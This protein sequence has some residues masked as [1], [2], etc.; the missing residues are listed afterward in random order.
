M[1]DKV[2]IHLSWAAFEEQKGNGVKSAEILEKLES[3]HPNLVNVMLSRINLERR[4]GNVDS[5]HKLFKSCI[6]KASK[7]KS[8]LAMKY[9]RYLR[10]GLGDDNA[11]LEVLQKALERDTK[12]AKLYLQML[13]IALHARPLDV[14][15]VT[16]VLNIAIDA[17]ELSAKARQIFSQRK[18]EFLG[19]FGNDVTELLAAKAECEKVNEEAKKEIEKIEAK[20]EKAIETIEGRSGKSKASKNGSDSASSTTIYP[21]TNSAS[22][23]A[24]H[25]SSYDQYGSRYDY[26]QYNQYY[27]GY[28]S[29]PGA[30][31]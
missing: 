11:A 13:D 8:D 5:V 27:Q 31:Y 22:Y 23:N 3:K 24:A 14:G 6:E 16:E 9:A 20:S 1:P 29:Q 15:R 4:Q 18:V 7:G 12:N 28:Y 2:N 10:L 19:D 26:G 25:N 30:S 17:K 21:A